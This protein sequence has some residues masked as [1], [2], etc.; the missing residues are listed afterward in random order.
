MP[1]KQN[2]WARSGIYS[3]PIKCEHHLSLHNV[4]P[5]IYTAEWICF[6]SWAN[7]VMYRPSIK[8]NVCSMGTLMHICNSS[9]IMYTYP[10]THASV[11][12]HVHVPQH[13]CIRNSSCVCASSLSCTSVIQHVHC[14][15]TSTLLYLYLNTC[16]CLD[17]MSLYLNTHLRTGSCLP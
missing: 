6:H 13:A 12:H 5:H 7:E 2:T 10:N 17:T 14:V 8:W 15:C 11:T 9:L 1:C 3:G 16:T 4:A